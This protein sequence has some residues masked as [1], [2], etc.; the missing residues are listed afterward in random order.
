MPFRLSP[1]WSSDDV[2]TRRTFGGFPRAGSSTVARKKTPKVRVNVKASLSRRLREIRQEIFGEHG[3]PELARRL[4]L[5]ARTWYN[6]ETGVT[7]P[8]EVLLGFIEQTG[9]SPTWL[10]NGE[11]PRYRHSN[12]DRLLS[13]LTP[14]E[15]IRRGLEELER[16]STE[17]IIVAPENLTSDQASE[18]VA[19]GLYPLSEI[20]NPALNPAMAEGHVLAYRHW[21][22][23]PAETIATRLTD[24]SMHPILPVGSIVAVDRSVSDPFKLH[25]QIVA[26]RP[27]DV[28]MIRWLDVSGRHVILRP[29]QNGRDFPLIPVECDIRGNRLIIGQVVW[30]WSRFR[31]T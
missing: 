29:N 18:F 2:R 25:G 9:A 24:E 16:T 13:E 26:A 1:R 12:D 15:L 10:L 20:A 4:N 11:G 22:P 7:V 31:Q 21:L 5:P 14:V 3:G 19:V 27:N 17:T 6:Y 23:N 8:A 28:P 30:S